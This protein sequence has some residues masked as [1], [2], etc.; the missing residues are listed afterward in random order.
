MPQ[1][2]WAFS[3][4]SRRIDYVLLTILFL[5]AHFGAVFI[6]TYIGDDHIV[7][8]ADFSGLRS[9]YD[10]YGR[11]EL[12]YTL[13]PSR[14]LYDVHPLL[15]RIT[16]TVFPLLAVLGFYKF[17]SEELDDRIAAM[18]AAVSLAVGFVWTSNM[19]I[20]IF[21]YVYCVTLLVWYACIS[22]RVISRREISKWDIPFLIVIGCLGV[23]Y[24]PLVV[25]LPLTL[26]SIALNRKVRIRDIFSVRP[27]LLLFS[28][29]A[30]ICVGQLAWVIATPSWGFYASVNSVRGGALL[31]ALMDLPWHVAT[32]MRAYVM[33]HFS[34]AG[35][36]T[37]ML[38]VANV[39]IA[40]AFLIP[41]IAQWR[42]R[43]L[44]RHKKIRYGVV[45]LLY[46]VAFIALALLPFIVAGK[47]TLSGYRVF[48]DT[49]AAR[50]YY[51]AC[52][53]VALMLAALTIVARAAGRIPLV[54]TLILLVFFLSL[55]VR[56]QAQVYAGSKLR[57]ALTMRV[58]AA[59]LHDP[60]VQSAETVVIKNRVR[61]GN[62]QMVLWG[63]WHWGP[64]YLWR[65][66]GGSP[67]KLVLSDLSNGTLRFIERYIKD[68]PW[69]GFPHRA[70][71]KSAPE[72]VQASLDRWPTSAEIYRDF[73]RFNFDRE[74]FIRMS[75]EGVTLQ[76]QPCS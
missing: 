21:P 16:V 9:V 12:P 48:N 41:L 60:A 32:F 59:A 43:D 33:S 35:S 65:N 47:V 30:V 4:D 52:I 14:L 64:G 22:Q 6:F 72:C 23:S 20:I 1:I 39:L 40:A 49:F 5:L 50:H 61:I 17:I 37:T 8:D 75:G 44:E 29:S 7:L 54:V 56:R 58:L 2:F 15:L 57:S 18:V 36:K 3:V 53:G 69:Y 67:D 51:L 76:K 66:L 45:L 73:W 42:G 46:S 26:L 13:L 27:L 19:Y 71:D 38:V 11:P 62:G 25:F 10:M 55:D 74:T 34:H 70:G 24:E 63:W 68:G 31:R 28:V